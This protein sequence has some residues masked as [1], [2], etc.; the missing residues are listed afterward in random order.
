MRPKI[1]IQ[2]TIKMNQKQGLVTLLEGGSLFWASLRKGTHSLLWVTEGFFK[3][4][5]YSRPHSSHILL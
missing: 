4:K 2:N 1:E 5:F 3:C